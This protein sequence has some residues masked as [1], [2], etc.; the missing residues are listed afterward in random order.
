MV[1]TY[2]SKIDIWLA[3]VLIGTMTLSL[4]AALNILSRSAPDALWLALLTGGVGF[5]LPLIALLTTRYTIQ[6]RQ[7]IVRSW[8]FKWRIPLTD[9]TAIT[10]T[11]NPLASPALSLDRLRIEY[12]DRKSLLISPRNKDAFLCQVQGQNR[13]AV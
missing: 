5:F 11:S 2:K 13:G 10:P 8:P 4:F 3:I 7:L 6:D 1:T 9:I 12:G